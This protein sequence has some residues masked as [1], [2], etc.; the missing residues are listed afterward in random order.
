MTDPIGAS[1]A[2]LEG[3]RATMWTSTSGGEND[4]PT[5]IEVERALSHVTGMRG[6]YA[7]EWEQFVIWAVAHDRPVRSRHGAGR[8]PR[9]LP[10][11]A[12]HPARTRHR[13]AARPPRTL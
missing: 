5:V 9:C 7:R 3:H 4:D 8:L 11:H 6:E 12:G 10:W 2:G 1:P 13:I